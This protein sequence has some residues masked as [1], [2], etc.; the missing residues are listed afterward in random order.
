MFLSKIINIFKEYFRIFFISN[1][2]KNSTA[3]KK[4]DIGVNAGN[5]WHLLSEKGC[6]T[7]EQI[8]QESKLTNNEIMLSIGWLSREGKIY[9]CSNEKETVVS[10]C[11]SNFYF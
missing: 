6:L 1:N 8:K 9:F 7:I 4:Q 3:M 10:L 2:T 11:D 5:I